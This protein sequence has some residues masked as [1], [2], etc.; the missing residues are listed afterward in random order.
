MSDRVSQVSWSERVGL[1]GTAGL[2]LGDQARGVHVVHAS[3]VR[4]GPYP[5]LTGVT[6]S[7]ATLK[8][9]SVRTYL[10]LWPG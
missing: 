1:P 6:R 2:P 10:A 7:V 3:L 9:L 8:T 5:D 4:C